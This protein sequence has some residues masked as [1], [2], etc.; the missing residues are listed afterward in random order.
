MLLLLTI[1]ILVLGL[2]TFYDA[3][4]VKAIDPYDPSRLRIPLRSQMLRQ[5]VDTESE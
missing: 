4:N 1:T 2:L 3:K 5:T